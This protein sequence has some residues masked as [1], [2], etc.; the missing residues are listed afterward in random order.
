MTVEFLEKRIASKKKEIEKLELRNSKKSPTSK[1]SVG[2]GMNC[3]R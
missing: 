1:R 3:M 2:G